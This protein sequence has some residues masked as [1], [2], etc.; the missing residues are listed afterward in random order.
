MIE[1]L[2]S[3]YWNKDY[4]TYEYI[5]PDGYIEVFRDDIEAKKFDEDGESK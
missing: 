1:E 3:A 5:H 4:E 2:K